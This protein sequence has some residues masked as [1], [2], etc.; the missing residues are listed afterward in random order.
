MPNLEKCQAKCLDYEVLKMK[1]VILGGR[2]LIGSKT[3]EILQKQGH[4]LHER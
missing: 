1:I 2:S 3:V 4:E